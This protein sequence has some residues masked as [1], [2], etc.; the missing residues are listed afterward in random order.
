MFTACLYK[1]DSTYLHSTSHTLNLQ[2]VNI[3]YRPDANGAPEVT[4][5]VQRHACFK[6]RTDEH[7]ILR[8]ELEDCCRGDLFDAP[9]LIDEHGMHAVAEE[10][11]RLT[12]GGNRR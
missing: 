1:I 8:A 5:I 9:G 2:S 4:A 11:C 6:K 3:S 7:D 10:A 12:R